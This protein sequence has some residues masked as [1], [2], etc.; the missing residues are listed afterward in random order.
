LIVV[1]D[2]GAG[3]L[4][5]LERFG[6]PHEP[7]VAESVAAG[8][9]VVLFSADKLIGAGQG[10]IIVGKKAYIDRIRKHPLARAFR[11]DKGCLMAIERTLQLFRDPA[12]LSE[13][14]PLYR[15][16][17]TP[18]QAL[19][20]RAEALQSAIA[21][22]CGEGVSPACDADILSARSAGIL[23]AVSDLT[24]DISPGVGYLGSGSL[25]MHELPTVLVRLSSRKIKASDLARR[26][27]LDQAAV[28]TR[29]EDDK[30]VL[31]MRTVGDNQVNQISAAVGRA[32]A[33]AVS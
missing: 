16:I 33:N 9:D 22:Q 1:D 30:V 10:G 5:G 20:A 19:Q 25:P 18:I 24:V 32:I 26:L 6:L 2:L 31:D 4:V 7:T 23:P 3:S 28:F 12:R 13:R 27:R 17:A 21:S 11:V 8:A 29:I 14:H 15:M